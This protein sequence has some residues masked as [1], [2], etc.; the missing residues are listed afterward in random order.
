MS[1]PARSGEGTR[2][3]RCEMTGI[4]LPADGT[5]TTAECGREFW[6][7]TLLAGAS[8]AL[9]RWSHDSAGD[10]GEHDTRIPDELVA[11]L[12]RV[13]DQP[14]VPLSTV[15]L[16]AHAKSLPLFR[17]SAKSRPA[18]SSRRAIRRC[19]AG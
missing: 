4:R 16:T 11:A 9:P 18:M 2:R 10:V 15:L 14:A 6:R 3:G 12:R 7:S 17:A 8:T 13:A 19:S 5:V 1:R